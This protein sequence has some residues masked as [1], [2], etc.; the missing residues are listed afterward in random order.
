MARVL[1]AT[2][3]G[4]SAAGAGFSYTTDVAE[5][6]V[7][8]TGPSPAS[9]PSERS[10]AAAR[11]AGRSAPRWGV[12][13]ALI[14]AALLVP[15]LGLELVLRLF[16]PIFPG[17][18]QL[19]V[20]MVPDPAYGHFN[21]R[22]VDVWSRT[23]EFVTRVRTN[24][25]G[26][27][28]PEL[29]SEKPPNVARVLALGDSFIYA[30]QV[31][32]AE[33][34]VALLEQELGGPGGT[35]Q[36]LNAGVSGW[37]TGEEYVY[38][39]QEGLALQPDVV[40]VFFYVGNDLGNN[41]R[42]QSGQ[43]P[44]HRGPPFRLDADGRLLELPWERADPL[45]AAATLRQT[46]WAFSFLET[47][48]LAKLE[49]A[50]DEDG[51]GDRSRPEA[52]KLDLYAVKETSERRRA[53][54]VTEALL[55]AIRDESSGAGAPM[56]LV[57]VPASY[58]V[59]PREWARVAPRGR[60]AERWEPEVPNRQLGQIAERLGVPYL[61]LLPAFRS[62][63]AAT[64]ERL[65]FTINAHWTALGNRLAAEQVGRF[66]SAHRELLPAGC[67]ASHA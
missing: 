54:Q 31:P 13:L 49:Q 60:D 28:G 18:Y 15:V 29:A 4:R 67:A 24:R 35:C 25:H 26:L 16:G 56:A 11:H 61:D 39:R 58:Q 20:L 23:S 46:S 5:P 64:D 12:R 38:L 62:E 14:G 53:W 33:T 9:D 37:G 43:A 32:E 55:A 17:E 57:A 42:R 1:S 36:V 3:P 45:P 47:G 7:P 50:E 10:W 30:R 44:Q 41:V 8:A 19:G 63:A 52:G 21:A 51:G 22:G 27:R 2:S 65:Y 34:A 6:A 48:V 66:L 40:L 59:Y